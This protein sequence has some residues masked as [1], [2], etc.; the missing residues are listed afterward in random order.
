MVL[1]D[2]KIKINAISILNKISSKWY[3]GHLFS[4]SFSIK[5]NVCFYYVP[6]QTNLNGEQV[7]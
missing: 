4:K 7:S 3:H 2:H 1:L 5:K 6:F